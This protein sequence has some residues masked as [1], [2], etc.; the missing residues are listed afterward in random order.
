[1]GVDLIMDAVV[2]GDVSGLDLGLQGG[3]FLSLAAE[4]VADVHQPLPVQ[5][6]VGSINSIMNSPLT[7]CR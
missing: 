4:Q 5:G 1:M 3:L 6:E 7:V 2:S